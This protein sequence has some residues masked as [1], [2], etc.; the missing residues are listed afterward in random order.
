[1]DKNAPAN[2]ENGVKVAK[3]KAAAARM[4]RSRSNNQRLLNQLTYLTP[5]VIGA[6]G[7]D[8]NDSRQPSV[9]NF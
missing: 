7:V 6:S 8:A 2:T 9:S 5:K 3:S 1:M 4:I